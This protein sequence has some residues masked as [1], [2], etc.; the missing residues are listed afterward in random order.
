[1]HSWRV[2]ILPFIDQAPLYNE[3]RFDEPWDG[4]NNRKLWSRMP[5]C[6]QLPG[7]PEDGTKTYYQGFVGVGTAFAIEQPQGTKIA[8]FTDGTSFSIFVV[9]AKSPVLWCAPG[10]IPFAPSPNGYDP[11]QVGGHF[12][13]SVNVVLADGSR[14]AVPHKMPP[15]DFQNA[16]TINDN[17]LFNWPD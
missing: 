11:K 5:K 8:S 7:K 12:G 3:Y 4:P 17:N 6:Y 16:I 2:L 15:K 13:P 10:D 14:R 9:E 1:M